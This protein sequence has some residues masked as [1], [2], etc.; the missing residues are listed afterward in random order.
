M[1]TTNEIKDIVETGLIKESSVGA[2][3]YNSI[4]DERAVSKRVKQ[5]ITADEIN[6]M[7][8]SGELRKSYG[9]SY[10]SIDN[11]ALIDQ[12]CKK[13][14]DPETKQPAL[15]SFDYCTMVNCKTPA[16]MNYENC[17]IVGGLYGRKSFFHMSEM[18]GGEKR[19]SIGVGSLI[20]NCSGEDGVVYEPDCISINKHSL[21][22]VNCH[23][24]EGC[25]IIGGTLDGCVYE[26]NVQ[27]QG[28]VDHVVN[29]HVNRFIDESE[30]LTKHDVDRLS[31]RE[32]HVHLLGAHQTLNAH[33]KTRGLLENGNMLPDDVEPYA[34]ISFNDPVLNRKIIGNYKTYNAR[35]KEIIEDNADLVEHRHLES[36]LK[37]CAGSMVKYV[38]KFINDTAPKVFSND[39]FATTN[40][41]PGDNVELHKELVSMIH[42]GIMKTR[43]DCRSHKTLEND[44]KFA[45]MLCEHVENVVGE[46]EFSQKDETQRY[47]FGKEDAKRM[48]VGAVAEVRV[49]D[50]H[51]IVKQS[52]INNYRRATSEVDYAGW[53]AEVT[54]EQQAAVVKNTTL[55]DHVTG[56]PTKQSNKKNRELQNDMFSEPEEELSNDMSNGMI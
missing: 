16:G 2:G 43:F 44:H 50:E 23:F 18:Y 8:Q 5:V 24:N 52:R 1:N 42:E 45:Q 54:P 36:E 53:Y 12:D 55:E 49:L 47:W 32:T 3:F 29:D 34:T 6:Q 4:A 27:V 33:I 37:N 14:I 11:M 9:E 48:I 13:I 21:G 51:N 15:I 20:K 46:V 17:S 28:S 31:W 30:L 40:L 26:K 35:A 7:I 56:A 19:L 22:S 38:G 10:Y 25:I 41:N 39:M